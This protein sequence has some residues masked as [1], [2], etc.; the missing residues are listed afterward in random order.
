M[1]TCGRRI[2]SAL[3]TLVIALGLCAPLG[4]PARAEE[5]DIIA[6]GSTSTQGEVHWTLDSGG[7]LTIRGEGRPPAVSPS[8]VI[9]PWGDYAGQIRRVVIEDGIT[10]TGEYSF[11]GCTNLTEVELASTVTRIN[12][13]AFRN[14]T[15]LTSIQFPEGLVSVESSAF[16]GCTGL[17]E[18][19]LPAGCNTIGSWAF[20]GC[21]G[22][23]ELCLPDSVTGIGTQAFLGCTGLTRVVLPSGIGSMGQSAFGNCPNLTE[24]Y[25]PLSLASADQYFHNSGS[26]TVYYEGSQE[27][28]DSIGVPYLGQKV[29]EGTEIRFNC[30]MPEPPDGE[31]QTGADI[32]V[33]ALREVSA[34]GEGVRLSWYL[35]LDVPG[36]ETDAYRILRR[37]GDGGYVQ[38]GEVPGTA[39]SF[40]DTDVVSGQTYTYTVQAC[41]Q[42]SAGGYDETGLTITWTGALSI[43]EVDISG[44]YS[45]LPLEG[46]SDVTLTLAEPLPQRY[47]RDGQF[48]GSV[49]L[50][51]GETL[52]ASDG[53]VEYEPAYQDLYAVLSPGAGEHFPPNT[54]AELQVLDEAGNVVASAPCRTYFQQW[55]APNF[56]AA[57]APVPQRLIYLMLWDDGSTD[58]AYDTRADQL[59]GQGAEPGRG[60]SALVW[61]CPSLW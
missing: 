38:I 61:R 60:A 7:T 49:R 41:R 21:T 17:T 42:G 3:L 31:S 11:A 45:M 5:A 32:P 9:T 28:W 19:D 15:G 48:A 44:G 51:A 16:S 25:W 56:D 58:R 40:T 39:S 35:P 52:L 29:P 1:R 23:E 18:L 53:Q 27:D 22:L 54:Q 59:V 37:T 13:G 55:A 10:S 26:L 4:G 12:R 47:L 57:D 34:T 8:M 50:V 43:A 20:S 6:E 2:R 30:E 14:C 33:P 36:Y 24:V 46:S